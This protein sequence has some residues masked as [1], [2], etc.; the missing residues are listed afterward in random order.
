MA[1]SEI[2]WGGHAFSFWLF[3]FYNWAFCLSQLISLLHRFS[4]SRP[5]ALSFSHPPFLFLLLLAAD[6]VD[7]ANQ[8]DTKV[9]RP[10]DIWDQKL[11]IKGESNPIT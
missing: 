7:V 9:K 4:P 2:R 1:V 10:P 5:T 3:P 8:F 6:G 11:G